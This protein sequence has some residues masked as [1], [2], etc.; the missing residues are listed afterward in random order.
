MT[1]TEALS[2]QQSMI[3][4][5]SERRQNPDFLASL[6][7]SSATLAGGLAGAESSESAATEAS[8]DK[9]KSTAKVLA[10]RAGKTLVSPG[11]LIYLPVSVTE[12]S[13]FAVY[14]GRTL[15]EAGLEEGTEL[16][17]VELAEEFS[18]EEF[19]LPA[20][21]QWQGVRQLAA[22]LSIAESQYL[23]EANAILNWHRVHTHCPRCGS[24]TEVIA[25]G[26]VRRCPQDGSEHFPRTDP[27]II[28]AVVGKG[29]KLLLG[30]GAG[31]EEH[32]Y[33]TL[34]GFVEPGESLEQ[35]V[36]REIAEEVGV[37]IQSV[38]YLG[39]QAWPFPASLMLGFIA[40]TDD[41]VAKPDGVEV[42][43][44]RWFSKAEL[45]S[46]VN[47]G[48]VIISHRVSIAR[49]LIEHWYGERI[50]DVPQR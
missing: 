36:L 14:L 37:R 6:G 25:S 39:S 43:R 38:Q 33:S 24:P 15:G 21:T 28:V 31:W 50:E 1:R 29:G 22:E 13:G 32:R 48:E 11:G 46:A 7:V 10:L 47:S 34:A 49:A 16:L 40:F 12:Q 23:I 8:T 42:V 19:D 9:P 35:A 27:A 41:E 20:D 4:R 2:W 17:T 5:G 18:L 44:A 3:D 26:W 45:L 30:G